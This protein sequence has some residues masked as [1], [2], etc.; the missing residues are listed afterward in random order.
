MMRP[1]FG[2][3][4]REGHCYTDAEVIQRFGEKRAGGTTTML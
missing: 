3:Y 2:F 4:S 1:D